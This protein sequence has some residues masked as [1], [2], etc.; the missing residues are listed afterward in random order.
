MCY[1]QVMTY[2]SALKKDGNSAICDNI[3][4]AGRHMLNEI[5]QWEK[6]K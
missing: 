2:Y 1:L 5:S 4:K 3:E 6:D